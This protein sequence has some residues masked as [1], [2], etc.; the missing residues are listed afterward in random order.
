MVSHKSDPEGD[1]KCP[2][3]KD[4]SSE[5]RTHKMKRHSG[6]YDCDVAG[7]GFKSKLKAELKRHK[8]D[9]HSIWLHHCQRCDKGFARRLDLRQHV[10]TSHNLIG[11]NEL[12]EDSNRTDQQLKITEAQ[13]VLV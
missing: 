7:C 1:V 10:K 2:V 11:L 12:A 8:E 3:Q 13:F 4:C 5:L 9:V 6:V